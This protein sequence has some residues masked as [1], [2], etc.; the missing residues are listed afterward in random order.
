[1]KDHLRMHYTSTELNHKYRSRVIGQHLIKNPECARTCTDVNFRI[2]GQARS[3][4]HLSVLEPVY[5]KTQ[6][7]VLYKQK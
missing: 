3:F 7:P 4:F 6:N 5:I 1:M 2:I